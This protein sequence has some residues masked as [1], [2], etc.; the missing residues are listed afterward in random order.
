MHK[1]TEKNERIKH[2]YLIFLKEAKRQD[3]SSIDAVAKSLSRFEE[4]T[5]YRD[6]K[7]FHFEQA[8]GFKKHLAKQTNLRTGAPLSKSTISSTLRQLKTFFEWLAMQPGYKSKLNYTD[9]EYFNLSEHDTRI[10]NAKRK[11][12]PPTIEQIKRTIDVME[13]T[14]D[15]EKRNRALLAFI[16]LTGVRDSAVA[17]LKLKH[18]NIEREHVFQDAREVNT[19]FRKTF[20]TFFFPVSKDIH[21]IFVDWVEHLKVNLLFG[22][23]D[24]LFPRTKIVSGSSRTF[25]T[26]G[27]TKEHWKTATP[28]RDIFKAAF[29]KAGLPYFNPH[30][31][32]DTLAT[33]GEQCCRSPEEFKSWSQ[34]LGHEG[35][36]T[37]FY[38]Y[39]EVQPHR[40]AEIFQTLKN[41][42]NQPDY[43]AEE[44]AMAVA[45]QLRSDNIG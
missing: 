44:I 15:I 31:F 26:S 39:G 22:L 3:E 13:S 11:K 23:D 34:N 40:Q 45:R 18:I 17:S 41:P 38:S 21:Q 37:T 8:V 33:F 14:S 16:L 4:Y 28:I 42:V 1:T 6:F 27:L 2:S 19:K 12:S 7:A 36:L 9:M 29:H 43:T 25:E 10:A 5:H 24:P 35:V 30:S 20:D 32:R